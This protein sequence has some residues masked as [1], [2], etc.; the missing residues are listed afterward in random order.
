MNITTDETLREL[1]SCGCCEGTGAATP[2]AVSNRPGLSAVSYRVGTHARFLESMLA[3]LSDARRPA[4]RNLNTRDPEDFSIAL[5][6]AWASVGDV[7]T[8]YQERIANESYL[9]TATE[10]LSVAELVRALG[11][12]LQPGVAAATSLAFT[13]D[14]APGSPGEVTIPAG[15]KAQSIPGPG[16]KPQ[17]FET[18][19]DLEARAAWNLLAGR[20]TEPQV[21]RGGATRAYLAGVATNLKAGDAIL[22]VGPA[23]VSD[24]NSTQ[25]EFRRLS[26]AE[27]ERE[28]ERTLV[29]WD[30]GLTAVMDG[31]GA[32]VAG[33]RVFA[34]R[35]RASVFGHNAPDIRFMPADIQ[36]VFESGTEWKDFTVIRKGTSD[37]VDLDAVYQKVTKGGWLVLT[38]PSGTKGLYSLTNAAEAGR[39]DYGLTG[40]V[41]RVTL[42]GAG[43]A[44]FDPSVRDTSVFAESEQLE[45]AE[46]AIPSAVGGKLIPLASL[47]EGLESGRKLIFTGRRQRARV[48]GAP[49]FTLL[50]ATTTPDLSSDL[51]VL[52]MAEQVDATTWK[53]P[54]RDRSGVEFY[55][56]ASTTAF[57]VLS[58]SAAPPAD[59]ILFVPSE[60]TDES[61][62]ELV[63]LDQTAEMDAAHTVLVLT[64]DLRNVY[65]RATVN[66][67]ANVAA[68]THGETTREVLGSGDAARAY[69]E[70]NLRQAPLTYTGADT[71]SGVASTLEVRVGG[72]L[73]EEVPALYGSGPK[74]RVYMTELGDGG[75]A[76]VKFGD[77]V[78]GARLPTGTENVEATYRKGI[79]LEGQV[80]AGQLSLLMT[81]P[82]GVRGVINPLAATGA[83]DPQATEDAQQNGPLTVLTLDRI[84]SLRD[85]E[86][87]ARSFAGVAKALATWIWAAHTRGL[88]VTVAGSEGA[89]V[90]ESSPLYT[91]LLASMRKAGDANV[92]LVVRSYRARTFKLAAL[93]EAKEEYEPASVLSAVEAALRASFSFEA[94]GFGQP[95]ARSEIVA[96]VHGVP[97]VAFV[98]VTQLYRTD[99]APG[100]ADVL[101]ADV[102]QPGAGADAEAAELLTLDESQ[103]TGLEVH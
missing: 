58:D 42:S 23:R 34:L 9:R 74:D 52:G 11:Y 79:G 61:V 35:Q 85:Y 7:L 38:L 54:L 99:A 56:Q 101:G 70:F 49:A 17:T 45:L 91:R 62:S 26:T 67:F 13:L 72:L 27:V 60:E 77:G 33:L 80:N 3:A 64:D 10:R 59:K 29:T 37:Q 20:T 57:A 47:V 4:L 43:L 48:S 96:V 8:F 32:A 71:P 2:V 30:G 93:V 73:W 24:P 87:F 12:E 69:Q 16:E 39:A 36:T 97:G 76:A 92:P 51:F 19:E 78:T 98:N 25:W 53:L 103:L 86:D 5:L 83:A 82:L 18:I 50:G 81:R 14:T 28:L 55:L 63:T 41:T 40:K 66:V 89:A 88:L 1:N 68:A 102:P 22:F 46:T 100:L 15:T 75:A 6:D 31:S 95:V 84:V 65:D 94:R 44:T 90:E 21:L